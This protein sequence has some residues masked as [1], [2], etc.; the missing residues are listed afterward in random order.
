MF[1]SLTSE[2]AIFLLYIWPPLLNSISKSEVT[3]ESWKFYINSN[4]FFIL[5]RRK[6]KYLTENEFHSLT[7][8]KDIFLNNT[9]LSI[10]LF[11]INDF[12]IN[13]EYKTFSSSING[14]L[15]FLAEIFVHR[16][17]HH[18]LPSIPIKTRIS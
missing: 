14:P 7:R 4:C 8:Q 16:I 10:E 13:I 9:D 11:I 1:S 3:S 17:Q 18:I 5:K 2:R 6:C 12:T 15:L